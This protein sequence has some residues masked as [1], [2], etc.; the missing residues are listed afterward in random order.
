MIK[1][2]LVGKF[3]SASMC[4]H[5]T[6]FINKDQLHSHHG[7]EITFIIKCGMK[8]HIHFLTSLVQTTTFGNGKYFNLHYTEHA[9]T[10]PCEDK[11]YSMLVK[12]VPDTHDTLSV[13]YLDVRS[14]KSTGLI[15]FG[16]QVST[17]NRLQLY[18]LKYLHTTDEPIVFISS[19]IRYDKYMDWIVI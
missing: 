10:C 8:L 13:K 14:R 18:T 12:R 1:N 19:Y 3:V 5:V 9:I 2:S 15:N 4:L 16:F 17:K 6:P 11:G 7:Y